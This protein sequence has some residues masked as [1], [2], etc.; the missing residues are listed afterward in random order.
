MRNKIFFLVLLAAAVAAIFFGADWFVN[1][2]QSPSGLS[3]AGQGNSRAL[4]RPLGVPS[5]GS[6]GSLGAM[7][8]PASQGSAALPQLGE[9]P[10]DD[11]APPSARAANPSLGDGARTGARRDSNAQAKGIASDAPSPA[12]PEK[13]PALD[14]AIANLMRLQSAPKVDPGEVVKAL[15]QLERAHGS[16]VMN[17]VKLDVLRNNLEISQRI[18][19]KA[20]EFD[21]MLKRND[22]KQPTPEM[23]AKLK[24]LQSL[25]GQIRTDIMATEGAK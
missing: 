25:Q 23:M 17:G 24:E 6:P 4:N 12:I 22:G 18:S 16:S 13:N 10:S 20:T 7:Q 2:R 3:G 14:S 15:D 19:Q 8:G 5:T 11:E 21:T 9:L 1:V